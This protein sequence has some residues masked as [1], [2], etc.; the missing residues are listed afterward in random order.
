MTPSYPT[1]L[2]D[3][4][5]EILEPLLPKARPGGRPRT[6]ALRRVV[7]PSSTFSA[8]GEPG[9]YCL[10]T[11]PNG[12]RS[13]T[14]F[15]NGKMREYDNK[16]TNICGNGFEPLGVAVPPPQVLGSSIVSRSKPQPWFPRKLAMT[17]ARRFE[18]ANA[19]SSLIPWD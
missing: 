6:V 10:M 14:T 15:D 7:V 2:S 18:D 12:R 19:I 11:F 3:A 4:Q 1:D 17:A 13:T 5:W 16:S 8:R 9:T